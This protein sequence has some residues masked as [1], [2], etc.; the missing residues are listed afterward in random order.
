MLTVPGQEEFREFVVV[1]SVGIGGIGNPTITD[2]IDISSIY[3]ASS[4]GSIGM[5]Y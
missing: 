3:R 1:D 4:C 5:L 2:Y